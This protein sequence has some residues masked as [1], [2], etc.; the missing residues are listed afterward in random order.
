M[1]SHAWQ[2][3]NEELELFIGNF[4]PN[5]RGFWGSVGVELSCVGLGW[6]GVP[7]R[8]YWF[9]IHKFSCKHGLTEEVWDNSGLQV[10]LD[11]VTWWKK[12]IGDPFFDIFAHWFFRMCFTEV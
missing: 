5:S 9:W 2:W 1:P 11:P 8:H 12:P 10:E 3:T 6:G 7:L 4:G